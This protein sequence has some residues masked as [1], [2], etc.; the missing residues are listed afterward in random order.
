MIY[1]TVSI[2]TNGIDELEKNYEEVVMVL[3][4]AWRTCG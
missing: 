4:F 2:T 1:D 3:A